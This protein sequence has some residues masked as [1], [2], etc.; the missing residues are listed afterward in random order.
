MTAGLPQQLV[1]GEIGRGDF[2]R[3]DAV[4]HQG[5][6]GGQIPRGAHHFDASVTG[7]VEEVEQVLG[8]QR[9]LGQQVQRVLGPK[10]LSA[11]GRARL[12]VEG[13]HVPQLELHA[14]STG[15]C[16][17]IHQPAPERQ[18]ALVVVADLRDHHCRVPLPDPVLPD[19]QLVIPVDGQCGQ[20]PAVIQ[21]RQVDGSGGQQPEDLLAGGTQR[22]GDH[23]GVGH[24]P[25]GDLEVGIRMCYNPAPEVAVGQGSLEQAIAVHAEDDAFPVLGHL[26]Q[27]DQHR[28]ICEDQV[29]GQVTFDDH[30]ISPSDSDE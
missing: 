2:E 25:H 17:G 9:V 6:H 7:M 19:P 24:L 14:V 16:G 30:G 29:G 10:V 12:A 11:A 27:S 5:L 4:V 28:V 13:V 15:V 21:Q 22:R 8:W 1:V 23:R 26:L 3:R 18:V 20:T